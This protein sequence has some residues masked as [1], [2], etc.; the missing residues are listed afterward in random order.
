[1][2]APT[3][4]TTDDDATTEALVRALGAA[5][6]A[7]GVGLVVA[8]K[9]VAGPWVG[10]VA[11]SDGGG[12]LARGVGVRDVALGLGLLLSGGSGRTGWVEAAVLCDLGDAAATL[13]ADD[14][15]PDGRTTGAGVALAAAAAGLLLRQ[16]LQR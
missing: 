5:R 11:G 6:V 15:A 7:V 16:R 9:L 4:T 3:D 14:L 8:P 10:G 13:A 12:V 1:M 2:T